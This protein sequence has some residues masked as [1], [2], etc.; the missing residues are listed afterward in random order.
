MSTIGRLPEVM[1][2]REMAEFLRVSEATV[3][4]YAARSRIPARQIEGEWRFWRAAIENWLTGRSAKEILLNQA[5]AF[6]DEMTD[7]GALRSSVY[8]DRGRSEVE[9]ED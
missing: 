8:R 5:G 3:R 9:Q 4:R 1:T 6:E 2:S 7:V